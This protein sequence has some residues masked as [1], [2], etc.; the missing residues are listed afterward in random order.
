MT[1][2]TAD[3]VILVYKPE[4]QSTTSVTLSTSDNITFSANVNF[5]AYQTEWFITASSSTATTEY[6]SSNDLLVSEKYMNKTNADNLI[7]LIMNEKRSSSDILTYAPNNLGSTTTL[8]VDGE[9]VAVDHYVTIPTTTSGF[10]DL[11]REYIIEYNTNLDDSN[12]PLTETTDTYLELTADLT[13]DLGYIIIAST[14]RGGME[15]ILS[16][17]QF[18]KESIFLSE[19]SGDNLQLIQY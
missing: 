7:L 17:G 2:G 11:H 4:D 12:N 3:E 1:E 15:Q 8:Q 14:D 5:E 16:N 10:E 18:F 9:N 19:I 13:R 6:G